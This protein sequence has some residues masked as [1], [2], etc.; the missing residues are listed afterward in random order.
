MMS[1]HRVV[2]VTEANGTIHYEVQDYLPNYY[3]GYEWKRFN[4]SYESKEMAIA[5]CKVRMGP[6]IKVIF[7]EESK[8]L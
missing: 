4:G 2:E 8:P 5:V 1:Q 3:D 6:I 7:P